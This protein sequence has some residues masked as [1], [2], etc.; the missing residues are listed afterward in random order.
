[1]AKPPKTPRPPK[2]PFI[3]LKPG[4]RIDTR[5]TDAHKIMMADVIERWAKL[6]NCMDDLIWEILK[7]SFNVGRIITNRMDAAGK[8]KLLRQ[9]GTIELTEAQYH[10]IS[11]VIDKID[12]LREDR[13]FIVHGSWGTLLPASIPI[14]GSV[15]P[16]APNPDEVMLETFPDTRMQTIAADIENA[17]QPLIALRAE[18]AASP[19]KPDGPH[20][21]G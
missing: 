14:C 16:N 19:R 12:L 18:L 20:P 21:G 7:V 17:K 6:E 10:R 4:E 5:I 13:N 8:I 1:M 15:R 11:P 9:L 3:P 2:P